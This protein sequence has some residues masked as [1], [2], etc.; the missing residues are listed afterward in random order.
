MEPP[1]AEALGY[2]D[3]TV[4]VHEIRPVMSN[5]L[6]CLEFSTNKKGQY[7]ASDVAV[8]DVEQMR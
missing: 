8:E 2:A 1:K 4:L 6:D 5:T 3:S 7:I